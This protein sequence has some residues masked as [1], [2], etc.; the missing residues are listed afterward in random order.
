MFIIKDK[1]N[2]TSLNPKIGA[3]P[4]LIIEDEDGERVSACDILNGGT[5]SFFGTDGCSS[6][7]EIRPRPFTNPLL[8]MKDIQL[9]M[10]KFHNKYSRYQLKAGWY[11]D[12]QPIGGHVHI[13]C[14]NMTYDNQLLKDNLSF[15]HNKIQDNFITN[16]L[17]SEQRNRRNSSGYGDS[18]NAELLRNQEHGVE[19]RYPMSWLVHPLVTYLYLQGVKSAWISTVLDTKFED[20]FVTEKHLQLFN[21]NLALRNDI[22]KFVEIDM[23]FVKLLTLPELKLIDWTSDIIPNWVKG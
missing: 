11:V 4:E 3:D 23:K 5:S 10:E 8:V 7:A 20:F 15:I 16:P 9:F 18:R 1:Y 22:A 14:K 13:G 21:I 6:T 2:K 17:C 19:F 12:G